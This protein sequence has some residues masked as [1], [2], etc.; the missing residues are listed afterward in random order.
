MNNNNVKIRPLHHRSTI[1]VARGTAMSSPE[2]IHD[3]KRALLRQT[4]RRRHNSRVRTARRMI[5]GLLPL[6]YAV[7]LLVRYHAHCTKHTWTQEASLPQMAASPQTVPQPQ[8]QQQVDAWD[9][10]RQCPPW[11]TTT[12]NDTLRQSPVPPIWV[13]SY[14]GSGSEMFRDLVHA[15]THLPAADV[16]FDRVC[17]GAMTCK[18]HWPALE[19]RDPHTLSSYAFDRRTAFLLVRHPGAALPSYRNFLYETNH[20]MPDHSQQAP[21]PAW[22]EWRDRRFD[23]DMQ[24]WADVIRTWYGPAAPQRVTLLLP[25]EDLVRSP[26]LVER[27]HAQ[28]RTVLQGHEEEVSLNLADMQCAWQHLVVDRPGKKRTNRGYKPQFTVPQ[29]QRMH[30]ELMQL[31]AEFAKETELVTLLHRYQQDVERDLWQGQTQAQQ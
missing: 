25:Y 1:V 18:T 4:A 6:A 23:R 17:Q 10:K 11:N 16:Y 20:H 3:M 15:W 19:G 29:L 31:Q 5:M 8:K 12:T 30:D 7:F 27:I 28:L 26:A 14:P 9:G 21:E 22:I 13:P 24:R 2:T